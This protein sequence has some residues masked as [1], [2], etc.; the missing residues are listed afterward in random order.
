[1]L[2][3][4]VRAS[5]TP[6]RF[7]VT[8]DPINSGVMLRRTGDQN[9]GWQS[10][11]VIVNGKEAGTLLQ[12]L[13]NDRQ[14][15]LDDNYQLPAAL[16]SGRTK[17]AIELR[18]SGPSWTASGYPVQSLVLR[19]ADRQAPAQV[20]EVKATGRT[21][22]AIALT[23]SDTPDESA[24][25]RYNVYGARTGQTEKLIGSSSVPGYLHPVSATVPVDPQGNCCGVSWSNGSQLWIHG[26]KAGDKVVLEFGVPTTGTYKL[27]TVLT[28]AAD[29]GIAKVSVDGNSPATFDGY[30][31][32]GVTNQKVNLGNATLAAGKHQLNV[33][34]TGKNQAAIGY[35]VGIDLLD[36]ELG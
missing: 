24:I 22:N 10:A 28:K 23:W 7:A 29:Y 12:P 16:T 3:D 18:P 20:T 5:T 31:P 6:I 17:L 36:L 33:V 14:R 27:S 34:I 15:W 30:V 26:T 19:Y 32:S 21:D 8:A 2:T 4:Q 25:A 35:L 11:T 13:G 1:M 9:V